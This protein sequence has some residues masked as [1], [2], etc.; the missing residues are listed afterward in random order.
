MSITKCILTGSKCPLNALDCA[1][2]RKKCSA[3]E[4]KMRAT[5]EARLEKIEQKI[6]SWE[7]MNA[8]PGKNCF[9]CVGLGDCKIQEQFKDQALL[10]HQHFKH[11]VILNRALA[12]ICQHYE[13]FEV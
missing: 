4:P 6:L 13:E 9:M 10:V 5:F 12:Q 11:L 1:G 8:V 2:F 3:R 7:V